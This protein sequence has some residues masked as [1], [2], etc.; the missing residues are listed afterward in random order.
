MRKVRHI[1]AI[2]VV[3]ALASFSA[4][5]ST[6]ALAASDDDTPADSAQAVPAESGENAPSPQPEAAAP[7][8]RSPV[9]DQ[10]PESADQTASPS[11][12]YPAYIER[13]SRPFV[14]DGQELKFTQ[15]Y[16]WH[17]LLHPEMRDRLWGAGVLMGSF[18]LATQKWRIQADVAEDDSPNR[19]HFFKR[20]QQLGGRGIVPAMA[21]LFY[22]GGSTFR[23]YHAKETGIMLGESA[24][25]TGVLC[26]AGQWALSEDRPREGGKLH[27]F[28]GIGHG[29]SGHTSTAASIAGVLSR[30]Y[31]QIEPDDGRVARTFKW[32]GKGLA[33][34]APVAVAYGRVNE[35]QHFAYSTILGLGIGFWTSNAVADA[36]GLYLDGRS[37]PLKPTSVGPIVGEHGGAGFGAVWRW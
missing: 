9:E 28:R 33:Y 20:A 34:G 25:L 24:L 36:H 26:V 10:P 16:Y 21:V 15:K 29:V 18:V 6:P 4:A 35:Q 12:D 32:I 2:V 3:V 30:Q 13:Y 11:S 22:L 5:G 27:P 19:E 8:G 14:I 31:L 17:R 23:D 37:S 7:E 1:L